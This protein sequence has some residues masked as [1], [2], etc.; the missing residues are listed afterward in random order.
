M[1]CNVY[2]LQ[3]EG[4]DGQRLLSMIN[5]EQCI[6]FNAIIESRQIDDATVPKV[7]CVNAFTG[8]VKNI[9]IQYFAVL[10]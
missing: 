5:P 1:E 2:D 10:R 6:I 3:E 4:V 8:S 9:P 7:F